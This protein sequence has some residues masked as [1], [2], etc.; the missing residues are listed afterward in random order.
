[1]MAALLLG[2]DLTSNLIA[3]DSNSPCRPA[4]R[5]EMHVITETISLRRGR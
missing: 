5:R 1:M 2:T 4:R 3:D